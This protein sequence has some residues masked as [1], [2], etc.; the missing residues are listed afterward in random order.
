MTPLLSFILL[1]VTLLGFVTGLINAVRKYKNPSV[2]LGWVLVPLFFSIVA[3]FINLYTDQNEWNIKNVIS[4][5]N[6]PGRD[7]LEIE[8]NLLSD[9]IKQLENRRKIVRKSKRDKQESKSVR[10]TLITAEQESDQANPESASRIITP[11]QRRRFVNILRDEPKGTF[12]IQYIAGDKEAFEYSRRISDMLSEAGYSLSG[13]IGKFAG[14]EAVQGIS[15]VINR[16]ETQP[17][18]AEPIFDAF[19][20][21]GINIEAERNKQLVKP[22]EVLIS[23]GHRK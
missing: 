3:L 8:N 1:L 21:I 15:I 14:N 19:R 17:R 16:N 2:K 9:T 22:L 6:Q 10:D 13:G 5:L 20:S 11:E 7:S 4:E 23:V 18:Y 12:R